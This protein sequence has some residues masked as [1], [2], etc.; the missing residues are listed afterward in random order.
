MGLVVELPHIENCQLPQLFRV[1]YQIMSQLEALLYKDRQMGWQWWLSERDST[2]LA[3]VLMG[4]ECHCVRTY[5]GLKR[6]RGWKQF[7]RNLN[8]RIPRLQ[9]HSSLHSSNPPCGPWQRSIFLCLSTFFIGCDV[10]SLTP[11]LTHYGGSVLALGPGYWVSEC[12]CM[13][14][15]MDMID[16]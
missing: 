1:L 8:H 7:I 4:C 11:T 12:V 5:G 9:F 10:F 6:Q 15:G 16:N 3:P 13:C 2:V 14:T